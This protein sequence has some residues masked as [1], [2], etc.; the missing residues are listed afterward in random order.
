M[1]CDCE[2]LNWGPCNPEAHTGYQ[3]FKEKKKFS[4]QTKKIKNKN[5][6]ESY[7]FISQNSFGN[8]KSWYEQE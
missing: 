7:F 3:L 5:K 1:T 4:S 2:V 6:N 8:H